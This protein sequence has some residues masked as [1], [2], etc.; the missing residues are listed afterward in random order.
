[1]ARY[2]GHEDVVL[3]FE[4]DL[5]DQLQLIQILDWFCTHPRTA[6]KLSVI[7][8]GK[9]P[10]IGRFKGLGQLT[11]Q[12]L[13]SLFSQRQEVTLEDL[14]YA[15]AAWSAFCSPDPADLEWVTAQQFNGLQFLK[16]ALIRH[17][18]QYPS[19]KSG[20]SR[21]ERQIL[22]VLV[23]GLR[24]FEEVFLAEQDKE[25]RVF[26]GDSTFRVYLQ[27]MVE[28]PAP[29][30]EVRNDSMR[31]TP[32]GHKVLVGNEDHVRLNG[33]DRWLGG[34]HLTGTEA[35]WR[36]DEREKRLKRADRN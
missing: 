2:A 21:S 1:M 5:Y 30:I 8:I 18:E 7:C 13:S 32:L 16:G 17:M 3:W 35:A 34:V 36:W 11:S 29:L 14:K 22:E 25:E 20:L 31:V 33:V 28:C 6:T 4:H 12:Q 24:H 9:F 10:G 26:L 15:A 23:T 27:R 19:V